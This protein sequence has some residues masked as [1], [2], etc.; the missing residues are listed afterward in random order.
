MISMLFAL[1]AQGRDRLANISN[2][3]SAEKNLMAMVRMPTA[4]L[5]S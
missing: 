2:R 3:G 1:T 4:P 5:P